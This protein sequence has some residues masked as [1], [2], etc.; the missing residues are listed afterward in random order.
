MKIKEMTDNDIH[1]FEYEEENGSLVAV[2]KSYL[3][4]DYI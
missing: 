2:V 4:L 3:V 1:I